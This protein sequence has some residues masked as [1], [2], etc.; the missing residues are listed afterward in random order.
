[1]TQRNTDNGFTLIELMVAVLILGIIT[2][3]A[4]PN[5]TRWI[6]QARRADA[7]TALMTVANKLEKYFS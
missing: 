7:Q 5:Y 3:I 2:A 4:V 6:T 1:M